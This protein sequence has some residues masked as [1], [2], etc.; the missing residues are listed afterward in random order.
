MVVFSYCPADPRVRREA[1][2]LAESGMAVD[3]I[4][5]RGPGQ[6]RVE[7]VRGT[8]IIRLP[9]TRKRGGKIRYVWDYTVFLALACITVAALHLRWRYRLVHVHNMPDVLV[10]SALIPRILGTRVLLDLHDP[11]P[12]VFMAKYDIGKSHPAIRLLRFL[13]RLSIGFSSAVLTANKSFSDL[14][15]SRGCPPGKIHVV[16]NSP[17]ENV[18]GPPPASVVRDDGHDRRGRARV[19]TRTFASDR[20]GRSTASR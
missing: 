3:I 16:M 13:E 7:T 20:R 17:Q 8:R 12:E 10:F 14:F 6:D 5:L 18:F 15:V 9:V 1:E 11:M 19:P 2:A 4:C